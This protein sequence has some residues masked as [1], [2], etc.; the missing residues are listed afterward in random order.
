VAAALSLA[1]N[2][3]LVWVLLLAGAF[4]P[5]SQAAPAR[6]I[7][8]APLAASDWDANRRVSPPAAAPQPPPPAPNAQEVVD[9]ETEDEQAP[10][11]EAP[12]AEARYLSDRNRRVEE[13][14]VSRYAGNYAR[15]LQAPQAG[16]AS[17]GNTAPRRGP[18]A[19]RAPRDPEPRDPEGMGRAPAPSP[20]PGPAPREGRA[21]TGA[22]A[23]P[24]LSIGPESLARLSGGPG[25]AG[26]GQAPEGERT[27]LNTADGGE[28]S[29]FLIYVVRTIEPSWLRR[30]DKVVAERDPEGN[31]FFYKDRAVVLAVT[32]DPGGKIVDLAVLRSSNVDFF[33]RV[34]LDTFRDLARLDPPPPSIRHDGRFRFSLRF[35]FIGRRTAM[36]ARQL[37]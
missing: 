13:E 16:A 14:T 10:P 6:P 24:D 30:M 25:M 32:L 4:E 2:V 19:A 36:S 8:L 35:Q 11:G 26:Y 21:P 7:A 20:S 9:L 23:V 31:S 27:A 37:R 34:A 18:A 17:A 12:P 3:A 22:G 33:D 28:L 1:A 29:K 15:K 5:P